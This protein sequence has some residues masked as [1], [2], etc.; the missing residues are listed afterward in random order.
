MEQPTR[1]EKLEAGIAE[2]ERQLKANAAKKPSVK[3]VIG[4]ALVGVAALG[5]VVGGHW[6]YKEVTFRN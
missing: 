2:L 6:Y 3:K 4:Y 5:L 1:K